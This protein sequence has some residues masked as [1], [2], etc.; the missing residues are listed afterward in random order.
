[1]EFAEVK[2][3]SAKELQS[4]LAEE[5]GKLHTSRVQVAGKQLTQVHKIK[6]AR[7]SIARIQTAIRQAE[8]TKN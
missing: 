6:E 5:Q 3:K 1:M 8:Q 7:R 4:L 2:N